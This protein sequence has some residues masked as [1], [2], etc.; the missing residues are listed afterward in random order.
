MRPKPHPRLVTPLHN[1]ALVR[2]RSEAADDSS[3]AIRIVSALQ[4]SLE[5]EVMTSIGAR[6]IYVVFALI[7]SALCAACHQDP[8]AAA[9]AF[10]A[11]GDKYVAARQFEAGALEYRN[12]LAHQTES[13]EAYYKLGLAYEQLRQLEK[14]H[15]AFVRVTE[16]DET[17]TEANLRVAETLLAGERYEDAEHFANRVIV[18]EPHHVRA[19]SIAAGALDGMGQSV[20]ARRRIDEALNIDPQS[21]A[22]L[23]AQ[24]SWQLRRGDLKP[25][26]ETLRRAVAYDPQSARAW[27]ALANAEWRLHEIGRA[28]AAL[29]KVLALSPD[30]SGAQRLL[31]SFYLQTSRAP[32]AEPYLR[33]LAEASS[34]DRLALADY[35]LA[36]N[37]HEIAAALL[38][39]LI[40]DPDK[41]IAAHAHLRRAVLARSTGA[42]RE[43]HAE[44]ELAMKQ[45]S[46]Q[47]QALV[48]KSEL[49]V[50]DGDLDGALDCARKAA[51]L[52]PLWGD[53]SYALAMVHLAR[54]EL[55][56]AERELKRAR[57]HV[58]SPILVDT[59]LARLALSR[60]D[61]NSAVARARQIV[62]SN[63]S[64][65]AYTLLS[66][67]LRASGDV[68]EARR[69][70]T[71]ARKTWQDTIELETELGYVELSAGRPERARAAF[72]RALRGSPSSTASRSGILV[73]YVADRRLDA[74][75]TFMDAWRS[76]TPDDVALAIL[77]AQIELTT[78]NASRAEQI[79]VDAVRRA[80]R[81]ADLAESLAQVYVARGDRGRAL[82]NYA[83]VAA[84]RPTSVEALTVVG[85]LKQE[86]GDRA[87]ARVAYERVLALAPDAGIA[88]NNLAWL[89]AED[90][91]LDDAVRVAE[92]AV[93]SLRWSPEALDTLGWVNYRQGQSDAAIRLLSQAV[94]KAPD[95]AVYRYHLALAYVSA[96]KRAEA[97]AELE[98]ALSLSADFAD[99][100]RALLELSG[101]EKSRN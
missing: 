64:A 29:Q 54:G 46:A 91:R 22:A 85:M 65:A 68:K 89:Y 11:S 43:A 96:K 79:L 52:Q 39:A 94:T 9:R 72:E 49:L 18:R 92:Q 37:K 58:S 19:L 20:A 6:V 41:E 63:P 88:A 56:D 57:D 8:S 2:H 28:E 95:N 80:P 67:A 1:A 40:R 69:L 93:K 90:N 23:S 38:Q 77:S 75:R 74:A 36:L 4:P 31:A 53:G 83:K 33:A 5:D 78:G 42:L 7:G 62:A 86:S 70:V 27:T 47:P 16:L 48:I 73:A 26:T 3:A 14:A 45:P 17:Y 82:Q 76:A 50:D 35:Y 13:A 100:R 10:I 99:A 66:Q 25:A 61:V 34:S 84:L 101:S 81:N 30:K 71:L 15:D 87:G 21:S 24:A 55:I 51:A 32:L 60:R 12:A 44:A 97:H 59:E 98:R